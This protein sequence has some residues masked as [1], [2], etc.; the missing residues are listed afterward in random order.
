MNIHIL[1]LTNGDT[2]FA[3]VVSKSDHFGMYTVRYPRVLV[4][5]DQGGS[6][7]V[8]WVPFT[9]DVFYDIAK[10]SIFYDGLLGAKFV[11]YFLA[12]LFRDNALA[13]VAEDN[14]LTTKKRLMEMA[15]SF[16]IEYGLDTDELL[17]PYI[18][19]LDLDGI[20]PITDTKH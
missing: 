12:S 17:Q 16:T 10:S 5:T 8:A 19:A 6:Q 1:K 7:F 3:D 13:I 2:V 9:D 14:F 18:D 15:E 20:A 4:R 11:Y